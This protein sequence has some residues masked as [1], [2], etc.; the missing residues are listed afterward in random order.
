MHSG[1][2]TRTAP[3]RRVRAGRGGEHGDRCGDDTRRGRGAHGPVSAARHPPDRG[4]GRCQR[5]AS[6]S[7]AHRG[8]AGGAHTASGQPDGSGGGRGRQPAACAG[9][10]SKAEGHRRGAG[11]A[12]V[13]RGAAGAPH[14]AAA[15]PG[16]LAR[17]GANEPHA[18]ANG[19]GE[20]HP[21]G[22]AVFAHR[23]VCVVPRDWWDV[24]SGGGSGANGAERDFCAAATRAGLWLPR[25]HGHC[26][27]NA[28]PLHGHQSGDPVRVR[29][30]QAP[31]GARAVR[32]VL[33]VPNRAAA[34]HR[35]AGPRVSK[36][37]PLEALRGHDRVRDAVWR[38]HG[39]QQVHVQ[40]GVSSGGHHEVCT[41][42]GAVRR[43]TRT[44]SGS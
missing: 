5:G 10:P 22:D 26:R 24:C 9:H 12:P 36:V 39:L 32:H 41:G 14:P 8:A 29:Q 38:R 44:C 11:A 27:A 17:P 37:W 1:C 13:R 3:S 23:T 34:Q 18:A 33:P 4:R 30:A 6:H 16:A 42:R 20:R 21:G 43:A 31:R 28:R 7:R 2:E 15:I 25:R 35:D 40:A 19:G